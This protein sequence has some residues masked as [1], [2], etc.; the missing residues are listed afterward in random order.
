MS[1]ENKIWI[2]RKT[3][4]KCAE[5]L[6]TN[7]LFSQSLLAWYAFL[8]IVT[9][10]FDKLD[11]NTSLI[12]SIAILVLSIF[13]LSMNFSERAAKMQILY[14]QLDAL[15]NKIS[16]NSTKSDYQE[17]SNLIAL[18]ENHSEFDYQK[19]QFELRKMDKKKYP[20]PV[21]PSSFDY[22]V[23]GFKYLTS[24]GI[25]IFAVLL[26]VLFFDVICK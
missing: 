14:T 20:T 1:L 25:K 8:L 7:N 16:T 18:T 4:I 5:R 15:S 3:R 6:K 21:K 10:V 9:T 12:Y 17:Y 24:Y 23:L 19:V 13:I 2:T 22:F 26:P 11:K